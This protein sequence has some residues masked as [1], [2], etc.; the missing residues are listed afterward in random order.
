LGVVNTLAAE[1]AQ[2]GL[3]NARAGRPLPTV[4]IKGHSNGTV[5]GLPPHFGR[6]MHTGRERAEAVRAAFIEELAVRLQQAQE[7][8]PDPIGAEAFRVTAESWGQE[9]PEGTSEDDGPEARRRV[10][11]T[12]DTAPSA[13]PDSTPPESTGDG[14][15]RSSPGLG[16]VQGAVGG[17]RDRRPSSL[18]R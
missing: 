9:L 3:E 15:G 5:P 7:G 2:E 12:V 17:S 14:P 16:G 8:L 4:M 1:V 18:R 10:V 11:I 6:A 13:R